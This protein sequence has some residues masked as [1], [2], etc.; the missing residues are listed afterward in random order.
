MFKCK[1][2]F[3]LACVLFPTA[4]SLAQPVST[5]EGKKGNWHGFT[6]V[7]FTVNDKPVTVVLPEKSANAELPPWVWHG[8]FFGH[9]PQPDIELLK[10]GFHIVYTRA[11]S[12]GLP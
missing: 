2:W 6:S 1:L 7:E 11:R 3:F 8:E 5:F 4:Q 10:R 9:R 12:P